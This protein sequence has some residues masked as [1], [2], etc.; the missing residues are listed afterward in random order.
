MF[1]RTISWNQTKWP[2]LKP[3]NPFYLLTN[4]ISRPSSSL[5]SDFGLCGCWVHY[6]VL[7]Q[8]CR[9]PAL[10][11]LPA[12]QFA[13]KISKQGKCTHI[14]RAARRLRSQA[15]RG[16]TIV[17]Q[18]KATWLYV[19]LCKWPRYGLGSLQRMQLPRGA[20]GTSMPFASQ[21]PGWGHA[22]Y[23]SRPGQKDSFQS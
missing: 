22:F 15:L 9:G 8:L 11:L 12:V 20:S 2:R 13:S 19:S 5:S 18:V 6:P 1:V 17:I 21:P 3:P 7:C 10:C 16:C 14:K 4:F 23:L